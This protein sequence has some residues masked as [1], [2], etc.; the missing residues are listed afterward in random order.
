MGYD[1]HI[2]RATKWANSGDR[3]VSAR[4]WWALV[5]ADNELE[6]DGAAEA[7]TDQDS[8]RDEGEGLTVWRR[9]PR[10]LR[11]CFEYTGGQIIIKNPDEPTLGKALAVARLLDAWVQGDDGETYEAAGRVPRPASRSLAE[12]WAA[13]RE[14]W[15]APRPVVAVP[16]HVGDRV[17]DPWGG[18]G[19][20]QLVEVAANQGLGL[21]RVRWDDGREIAYAAAG[22][23]LTQ[24]ER[25]E[26]PP[27]AA[28]ADPE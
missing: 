25:L 12:R 19:T 7:R 21:V 22:H 4:E 11:V 3:P 17:R 9:H 26:R 8:M 28:G 24:V 15:R 20:V 2:T 5:A 6:R 27:S 14:G 1:I 13:W 16:F 23:G 10:G 18:E